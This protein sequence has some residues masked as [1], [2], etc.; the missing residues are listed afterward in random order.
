MLAKL[1]VQAHGNPLPMVE[2]WSSMIIKWNVI[3]D[4]IHRTNH[5][6]KTLVIDFEKTF[7]RRSRIVN[8]IFEAH[9]T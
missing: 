3:V 9:C 2:Y 7:H 4:K 5:Q 1:G 6:T 8:I